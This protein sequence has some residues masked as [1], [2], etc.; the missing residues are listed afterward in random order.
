MKN[1]GKYKKHILM[2]SLI[3]LGA[4]VALIN[5]N[6]KVQGGIACICWGLAVL[7]MVW[8]NKQHQGQELNEFDIESKEILEDIVANGENSPYY[9]FYNIEIVNKLRLK[10]IKKH[11][12]Q[13]ISCTI[14]GIVLL[15][16][17]IICMV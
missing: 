13:T 5:V 6:K 7:V 10:L 1:I 4:I 15:I 11:S 8:I 3:I 14:L 16:T 17:A 2:V 9:H 12:K